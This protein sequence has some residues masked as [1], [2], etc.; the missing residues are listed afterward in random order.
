MKKKK[1]GWRRSLMKQQIMMNDVFKIIEDLAPKS[2]AY[3]WDNVGLQIGSTN[4]PV[5]KIMIT[6]D[7]LERVVDEAIEKDVNLIIAHHPLLFKPLKQVNY[8][9]PSGRI[10]QKLI[11]YDITVYAAHTN[12]DVAS[13]GVN[14]TLCSVLD[15]QSRRVLLDEKAKKLLKLAIYVPNTHEEQ[16]REAISEAGAGH[17]GEYSHC[18][19]KTQGQGTFKPLDGTN[20]FIGTKGKLEYVDEVK[21]ET[22]V[23]EG[24]LSAVLK[25]ME[26]AHPYEEVAYDIFPLENEGDRIGIGRIGELDRTM[27]LEEFCKM[28]KVKLEVSQLRVTGDLSK[29]VKTV[30]VLG[31]SGEKYIHQAKKKGADVYITGDMTFHTAQDAWQ[32]GLAVIDPGHYMEKVMKQSVKAYL[33][34]KLH[35]VNI[36]LSNT[37]TDPFQF[38]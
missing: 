15:L 29:P 35:D 13:G 38:I 4:K 6:L 9:S 32:M 37:N 34:E 23:P 7:V 5:K 28:I 8:D 33:E 10:L 18:T 14:D 12:L 19:F 30:A 27:T 1:T 11:K 2:L 25:E 3:E 16:V 17:I 26:K 31:G 36:I 21:L 22:I 20:P 24:I